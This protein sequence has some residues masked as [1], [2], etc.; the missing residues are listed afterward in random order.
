M[1]ALR[2]R[3]PSSHIGHFRLRLIPSRAQSERKLPNETSTLM[4]PKLQGPLHVSFLALLLT[5][6]S[7]LLFRRKVSIQ[8]RLSP[9]EVRLLLIHPIAAL[10]SDLHIKVPHHTGKNQAK[11]R[12][13]ETVTHHH[14]AFFFFLS[15]PD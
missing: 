6:G 9:Q 4:C 2:R 14:P 8:R 10:I 1:R 3:P 11:L 5:W 12:V 7:C 15:S 13:C